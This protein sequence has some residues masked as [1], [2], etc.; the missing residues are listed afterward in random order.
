[1]TIRHGKWMRKWLSLIR[2]LLKDVYV[3]QYKVLV[4]HKNP[5]KV[6]KLKRSIY[7][8][9]ATIL[10]LESSISSRYHK[11]WFHKKIKDNCC[12]GQNTH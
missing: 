8:S 7:G 10:N 3:V 4:D 6:C 9:K 12:E 11:V 2:N 1:M 5:K